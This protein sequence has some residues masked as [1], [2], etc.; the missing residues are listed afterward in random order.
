MSFCVF[1]IRVYL[2]TFLPN[3]TDLKLFRMHT[4]FNLPAA[5]V[6]MRKT[7]GEVLKASLALRARAFPR[8]RPQF[9]SSGPPSRQITKCIKKAVKHIR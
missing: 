1:R 5:S 3:H 2:L 9:F 6:Q 8:P 7:V 4:L